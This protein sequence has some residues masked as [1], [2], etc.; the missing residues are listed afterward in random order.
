MTPTTRPRDDGAE[1]TVRLFSYG[2]LQQ[3][4]VQRGTFGHE[5]TGRADHL[6]GWATSVVRIT[7]PEVIALSGSEHHPILVLTG[8]L[9]DRVPGT[10][11]DL[12][13]DELDAADEY[14]VDDYRRVEVVLASGTRSWVYLDDRSTVPPA[15]Q[16][17]P[18]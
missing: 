3:P 13:P 10:V 14:E 6:V 16:E 1:R 9:A 17:G 11:L 5:V 8:D 2:T 18:V 4:E 12:T 15:D 7:D